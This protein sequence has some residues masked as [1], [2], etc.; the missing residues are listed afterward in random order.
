MR[1]AQKVIKA[2]AL[3]LAVFLIVS[4]GVALIG[5]VSFL[6]ALSGGDDANFGDSGTWV[7]EEYEKSTVRKL[8]MNV[9]A[10]N[11]KFRMVDEGDLVRVETNNE[12]VTTW[13][14]EES[15]KLNVV[16]KSHGIFGWGGVGEVVVYVRDGMR[17]DEVEVEVGAGTL[18]IEKLETRKLKLELGAGKTRIENLVVSESA[19]IDGGAGVLEIR[20][21]KIRNAQIELG[22]GKAD[23]EAQLAGHSKVDSGVG[24]LDL[25]LVGREI[26]YK[27]IVDKGL[28]SIE[29][30]GRKVADGERIGDGDNVVDIDS[31][32]GA[33]EI[34]T[35]EE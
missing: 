2:F 1:G 8:E 7:G 5:G 27:L 15:G 12:Y 17:F 21:G 26:D 34:R 25:N 6:I 9:K 24:K 4:M 33:V 20:Q 14:D 16:E 19:Q 22:A 10:T 13:V 29:Y 30:N 31:G 11:V 28:G 23:I 35:V 32:V 3:A 18:S